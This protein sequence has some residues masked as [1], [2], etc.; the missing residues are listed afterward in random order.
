MRLASIYF[1]RTA[2]SVAFVISI[3]GFCVDPSESSAADDCNRTPGTPII[4]RPGQ[5]QTPP[6][7]FD[8]ESRSEKYDITANRYLWCIQSD[9]SNQNVVFFKWGDDHN[10]S[11]YLR[12]LIEPGKG[13]FNAL[14]DA[15]QGQSYARR[16]SFSRKNKSE[17]DKIDTQTISS[18]TIGEIDPRSPVVVLVQADEIIQID[19]LSD[20]TDQYFDFLSKTGQVSIGSTSSITLPANSAVEERLANG[21]YEKYN[22]SDFTR[23]RAVALSTLLFNGGFPVITYRFGLAPE[24]DTDVEKLNKILTNKMILMRVV[25]EGIDERS[26]LRQLSEY[27]PLTEKYITTI[28]DQTG[29]DKLSYS[30]FDFNVIWNSNDKFVI[31]QTSGRILTRR[32]S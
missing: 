28:R 20:Q 21:T 29:K 8:Y 19:K 15:S 27:A 25:F 30:T 3:I 22:P 11:R 23:A 2:I 7:L 24:A 4:S 31:T 10:E 6:I 5:H 17:W 32:K 12:A 18:P 26:P 9:R 1:C 16:I 13:A 14:L